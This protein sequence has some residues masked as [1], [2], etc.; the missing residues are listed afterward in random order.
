M[1]FLMIIEI[2]SVFFPNQNGSLLYCQTASLVFI[3]LPYFFKIQMLSS[4]V[5]N[6]Y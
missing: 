6:F 4:L 2:I 3:L 1:M 5:M